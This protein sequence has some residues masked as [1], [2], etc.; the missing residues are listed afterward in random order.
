MFCFLLQKKKLKVYG[1]F[2]N[3][4]NSSKNF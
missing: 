3:S 1:Q 4:F 2:L